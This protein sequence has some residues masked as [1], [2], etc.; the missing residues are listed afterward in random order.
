ME[1]KRTKNVSFIGNFEDPGF[2][3]LVSISLKLK[4]HLEEKGY[5]INFNDFDVNT[6]HI[7]SNGFLEAKKNGKYEK[8]IIYSLYS[9]LNQ[10]VLGTLR[11][12]AEYL[13]FYYDSKNKDFKLSYVL[14]N[15]LFSV[16]SSTIPISIKRKYLSKMKKVILPNEYI[17]NKLKLE[18]SEVIKFGIDTNKFMKFKLDNVEK[19]K[20]KLVVA[21]FGHNTPLKGIP[22]FLKVADLMK[23]ELSSE[24]VEFRLYISNYSPKV[25]R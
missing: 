2:E 12:Y 20:H 15:A 14:K 3:G 19:A 24:N 8:K 5:K 6:L 25:G 13:L 21:Y 4:K 23:A 22:D 16:L 7:H 9:N 1:E 18:N 17:S 11:Y 10:S